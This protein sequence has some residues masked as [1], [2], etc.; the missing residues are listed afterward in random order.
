MKHT[1]FIDFDS[2]FVSV[3][4]LDL[5]S[6]IVFCTDPQRDKKTTQIAEITRSGME[7]TIDYQQSLAQRL[8]LLRPTRAHL[9]ELVERL[10]PTISRSFLQ[11]EP[12]F[13][14]HAERIYILSGGFCE[15]IEPVVSL[16]GIQPDHILA[17]T[18]CF[19][20]DGTYQ[21][22]DV[23]NPLAKSSLGKVHAIK[24]LGLDPE[25]LVMVGDGITDYKV[26]EAGIA[27]HFYAYIE[28]IA[29]PT[30]LAVAT[31]TVR[32]WDEILAD[33]DLPRR[34]RYP[35]SKIRVLLLE[36][37][38]PNALR[39]FESEGYQIETHK[40]SL[41]EAELCEKIER[42]QILGIRS[43]TQITTAVI[44][45]A[46]QLQAVGA[47][48][49][50]TNQ[51]D[52]KSAASRGIAVFNAPYSNTR[53]VVELVLCEI[54]ALQRRLFEKST[55]MHAGHWD[56]SA[57]GA[58]EVRGK[59]LGII[60]YGNIGSQLSILAE[61]LGMHVCYYDIA[62][63]LTLGNAQKATTL[64][65]LL[66]VA[67]IVTVHVDGRASNTHLIGERE[68]SLMKKTAHLIN[69]SRGHVVDIR[70]LTAHL[71]R[72]ALAGA[73]IDVFPEEPLKNGSFATAL[74]D[75]PN[76][77]LTPHIAGSTEEAQSQIGTFVAERLIEYINTGST[78]LSVNFPHIQLEPQGMVHRIIH[79]HENVPGVLAAINEIFGSSGVNIEAQYLKTNERVG[80]VITDVNR[81]MDE[82][83][84][85][86]LKSI[87]GTIRVRL[88]Y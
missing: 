56:K 35:K 53:S 77:I 19:D 78:S 20:V 84:I 1:F 15:F 14:T 22:Y 34:E 64:D 79:I 76:V 38:H 18:L 43:K 50:G 45:A 32:S 6:E 54:I 59:T 47:F 55:Q 5:L 69:A 26:K 52:L 70:A 13:R 87:S 37:I 25:N 60:G 75:I 46:K 28:H 51:V 58:T 10:K 11:N 85:K 63:K 61:G 21:G 40:K 2:T 31:K 48:C 81:A 74:Q 39:L 16:F 17:N 88:L 3:E 71:Q 49:I 66:K 44:K 57:Q 4:S 7:G 27:A 62:Q 86:K 41:S 12:F 33:L 23:A 83:I 65:E 9:T 67:D 24:A 29:R 80:Y 82:E 36:N 42:V 68:L 8:A 73:A 30:V 72:G